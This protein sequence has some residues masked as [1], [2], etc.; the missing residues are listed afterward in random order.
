M[1]PVLRMEGITK[2]YPGV[3]ANDRVSLELNQGEILALLGE[4]G[5]GKSTLMKILY[6]LEIPDEGRIELR[7]ESLHLESPKDAIRAGIGM[8]HQHF[9]LVPTLTVVENIALGLS[10]G[11]EPFTNLKA[12]EERIREISSQYRLEVEPRSKIW[13]LSVGEQQRV[14]II[15]AIYRGTDILILDEPTAVLTPQEVAKLFTTLRAL[16]DEGHSVIFISHKLDEVM[17][18]SRRIMVIMRL[19]KE[20]GTVEAAGTNAEELVRMMVGRDVMFRLDKKEKVQGDIILEV[21]DL[22][23]SDDRNLPAVRGVGFRVHEGEIYGIAGVDGNGQRELVESITGLRRVQGGTVSLMGRDVTGDSPKRLLK[24]GLGHIPEDRHKSGLILRFTLEENAVLINHHF[25][26]FSRNGVLQRQEIRNFIDDVI[27]TFDVR[28]TAGGSCWRARSPGGNQQKLVLGREISRKPKLLVAAQPTRGLDVGAIEFVHSQLLRQRDEGVAILLIS[29]ELEELFA[30]SDT[31]AVIYKGEFMGETPA[32]RVSV[33]EVGFMMGRQAKRSGGERV[34]SLLDGMKALIRG[35]PGHGSSSRFKD[36]LMGLAALLGAFIVCGILL[37][38]FGVNPLK[39]YGLL[40]AG[41][42]GTVNNLSETLIQASP[43]LLTGLGIAICFQCGVWNVGAEGQL[44]IGA[45]ATVGLGVNFLGL[46]TYLLLPVCIVGAFIAGGLW[47]L[48]PGWLKV[49]FG[50]NEVIVTIMLNYIAIIFSTYLISGPWASGFTP[51]TKSIDG[52][53]RLPLLIQGTRLH[54]GFILGLIMSGLLAFLMY[55]TVFG[56]QI[57]AIGNNPNAA[58]YAGH[59]GRQSDDA[60]PGHRRGPGR[61]RG[62]GRG[63]RHPRQ[64]AR[65]DIPGVRLHRHR[66]RAPGRTAPGVDYLLLPVFFR[67]SRG[68]RIHAAGGGDTGG[69]GLG[70]PGIDRDFHLGQPPVD[71]IH[72]LVMTGN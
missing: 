25:L 8:V 14:E 56:Y 72:L 57:R 3:V 39:A 20:V 63:G 45:I 41:A 26:P 37:A 50:A 21:K 70:A 53:A 15:K 36:F 1:K 5:A 34:V 6:G 2:A 59:L 16:T 9:M 58:R 52:A 61:S 31:M 19:G 64:H 12:A 51:V 38:Y 27:Q 62:T 47:G 17:E 10:S 69:A 66:R 48:L 54:S 43:L 71:Q 42:F 68:R 49:R 13:Q 4:N 7:G 24:M 46:P 65:A 22:E 23:V 30:L 35:Q 44:Y 29:V 32:D 40:F 60:D 28:T 18:I 55:R 67:A 33:E 11:R